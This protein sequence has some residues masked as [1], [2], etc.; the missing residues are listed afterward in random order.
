MKTKRSKTRRRSEPQPA[1]IV[2]VCREHRVQE[3]GRCVLC[4]NQTSIFDVEGVA[5]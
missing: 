3:G 5:D 4:E 2:W 1:P